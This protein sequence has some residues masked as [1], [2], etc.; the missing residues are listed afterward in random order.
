MKKFFNVS[1]FRG[2]SLIEMLVVIAVFTII[3]VIATQTLLFGLKNG[4][5]SDSVGNVSESLNYAMDVMQRVLRS[6]QDVNCLGSTG[7]TLNFTSEYGISSSFTC[8]TDGAS[9]FHYIASSSASTTVNLTSVQKI[10]VTNCTTVF[11]SICSAAVPPVPPEVDIT[12]TGK[13]VSTS[14]GEGS[15]I[16]QKSRVF[17]R[18]YQQF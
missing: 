1:K 11:T 12:L 17:L 10:D 9:G 16:T 13:D 5:K 8:L 4:R 18:N 2:F 14:G 3:I 6:A 15:I 7:S